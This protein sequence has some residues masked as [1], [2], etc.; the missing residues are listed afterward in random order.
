MHLLFDI[1]ILPPAVIAG[2]V[3]YC[4]VESASAIEQQLSTAFSAAAESAAGPCAF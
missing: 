4:D 1:L 2:V 3:F